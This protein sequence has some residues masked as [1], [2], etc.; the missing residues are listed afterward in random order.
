MEQSSLVWGTTAQLLATKIYA[1]M[2]VYYR[3][4]LAISMVI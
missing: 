1:F 4:E 2:Y 3:V